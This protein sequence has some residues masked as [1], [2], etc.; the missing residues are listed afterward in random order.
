MIPRM[1]PQPPSP[2]SHLVLESPWLLVIGIV[3][4]GVVLRLVGRQRGNRNLMRAWWVALAAAALVINLAHFVTTDRERLLQHTRGLLDAT[5]PIKVPDIMAYLTSDAV[6]VGPEGET[7]YRRDDLPPELE[8]VARHLPIAS[9]SLR[10]IEAEAR[11]DDQGLVM[12]D[13]RTT[14]T[15]GFGAQAPLPSKWLLT[16]RKDDQGRWRISRIQALEILNQK[17]VRGSWR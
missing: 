12:I 3:A 8:S 16:W 6:L 14:T 17:A 11:S 2:L 4:V 1:G 7:W 10:Y 9:Q 15:E 13:L 5:T